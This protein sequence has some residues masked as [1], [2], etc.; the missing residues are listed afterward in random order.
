MRDGRPECLFV[1]WSEGQSQCRLQGCRRKTVL[2]EL[3]AGSESN[4]ILDDGDIVLEEGVYEAIV[5]VLR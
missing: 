1:R 4:P 5:L 2:L 3:C